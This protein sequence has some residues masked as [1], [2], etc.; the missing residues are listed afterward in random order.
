[1]SMRS[2][3][4]T[5][6]RPSPSGV[7]FTALLVALW[8]AGGASRADVQGQIVIRGAAAITLILAILFG[9]RPRIA[10][11]KPV[12]LLLMAAVVV[13]LLQLVPLPPTWWV[14]LPGRG[15]VRDVALVAG[16]AQPW[17]P[18]SITPGATTNA[19]ASLIVPVTALL[20]IAGMRTA[21]RAG[22]AAALLCF[23]TAST[24][25]ALLQFSGAGFDNPLIND[26]PGAVSGSFANRNHFA[27]LLALG[28]LLVPGWIFLDGRRP[29]W[30][31]PVGFGLVLLFLLT[32][33]ATGSRA[34]A[35]LGVMAL[36]LGVIL[37][38]AGIHAE[39]RRYP[40]WVSLALIAGVVGV[41]AICVLSSIV[42]DRAVSIDRVLEA[43]PSQDMRSRGLSTV[44]AMAR[45]Y[46]PAGA[47]LG[48]FE[49]MFRAH[50][51]FALLKLTYFNHAH[52]DLL[53]VVVDAGLPG[54]L[55]LLAGLL[56][57]GWASVIA[58]T[59]RQ[60]GGATLPR[61]GSAMLLLV[62]IASLFDYPART[63]TIMVI[64]MIAGSWLIGEKT[65]GGSALPEAGQ[66]L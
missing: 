12:A 26:T 7:L 33:L 48:G 57:W 19:A 46:F 30:R 28:C 32:I 35:L 14:M 2:H 42:A 40:R 63:P 47:G 27:L 6:V 58:W 36:I 11:V 8:I 5:R 66:H 4:L 39:L 15:L 45:D 13:A 20:L 60:N 56:W 3:P 52:N 37:S 9:K 24:I 49:P 16:Q 59:A 34:G 50:E 61:L 29:H 62:I 43:D 53:E 18:W 44:L 10:L 51:P 25:L 17:R 23:V 65:D 64:M 54:L 1:M 41:F 38:W 21:E 22:L 31:A 55:L